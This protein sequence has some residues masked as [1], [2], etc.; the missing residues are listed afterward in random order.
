MVRWEDLRL[1]VKGLLSVRRTADG[2]KG[3]F[4]PQGEP[5]VTCPTDCGDVC[6]EASLH[7]VSRL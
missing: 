3:H 6:K 5:I 2:V 4:A 1:W 7:R